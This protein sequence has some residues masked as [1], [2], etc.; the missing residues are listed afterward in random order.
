MCGN[1]KP[2]TTSDVSYT[3]TF[4]FSDK[5]NELHSKRCAREKTLFFFQMSRRD[6]ICFAPKKFKFSNNIRLG[7]FLKKNFTVCV[8]LS[9]GVVYLID[10]SDRMRARKK[11][12]QVNGGGGS[13][14]FKKRNKRRVTTRKRR[15]RKKKQF[16]FIPPP[17]SLSLGR[18]KKKK[19]TFE[20]P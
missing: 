18:N 9:G 13:S 11:N 16:T 3:R 6:F 1:P 7:I 4:F 14:A 10:L 8:W 20:I 2:P 5:E 15:R 19:K 17:T 12:L